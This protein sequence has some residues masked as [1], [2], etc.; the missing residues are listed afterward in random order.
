M[1]HSFNMHLCTICYRPV[2]DSSEICVMA[3][4]INGPQPGSRSLACRRHAFCVVRA[5]GALV[6]WVLAVADGASQSDLFFAEARG[7]IEM[8]GGGI[9]NS[10]MQSKMP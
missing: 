6:S 9:G 2:T 5:L 7:V 3:A 8:T 10:G 1:S 4:E